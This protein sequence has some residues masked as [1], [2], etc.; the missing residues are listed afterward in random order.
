MTVDLGAVY[1]VKGMSVGVL[2]DVK[3]WI[4][5]PSEV[6]CSTSLDGVN[7]AECGVQIP[8]ASPTDYTPQTERLQFSGTQ[9]ARYLKLHLSQFNG[10]QIPEWH[11]GRLNPTW[12]FADE[13]DFE[14]EALR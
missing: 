6:K 7:Y 5:A 13:S 8:Q 2:Q 12:V 1:R 10:G 4:W 3:S 9:K 11:L 14:I